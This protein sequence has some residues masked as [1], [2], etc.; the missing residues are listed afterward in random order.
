MKKTI[1]LVE[2]LIGF[3]FQLKHLDG[4]SYNIYTPRGEIVA[5]KT[6]KV[7]RGLGMPFLKSHSDHGNLIIDFHVQMPKRGTLTKEQ[8]QGLA[9]VLPGK[10]NERPKGDYHMLDDF[11]KEGVN[12]SEEGG[13][14]NMED[15]EEEGGEGG[16]GCQ[17]Q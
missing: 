1:S 5:D 6:R 3:Q 4:Q 8:L 11:D 9:T 7:V 2:A 12:T 16:I 15:E 14:K 17:G 13:K 10:I